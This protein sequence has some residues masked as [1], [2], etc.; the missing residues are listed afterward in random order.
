MDLNTYQEKA[1]ATDRVPSQIDT[2]DA[3]INLV[4]P[5][6]GLA[7]ETG[8]L[9]SEY[10][11]HLRDG[12]S[13]LL[14]K[15]R[16]SE[17]LG[18]L[19]WY[20]A[21]VAKKF[22]IKLSDIAEQNLRKVSG[23]W[24]PQDTGSV[25]FDSEYE[26]HERLPLSFEVE[27]SEVVID[28]RT[29]IQM[30][31]NGEK[32]GDDLTD[33]ADDPDGYRFHDVFHLA[34]VAVLGWSPVIRKLMKR[35]RKSVPKVDE[36]QDGGRAQ[37]LDEGVAALVF[38]YAKEHNW[39]EGVN[40]LDYKLLRTIKGITSLLEV[41]ERSVGEWQRAILIGF[42]VWRKVLQANGGRILVDQNT[43][44]LVFLGPANKPQ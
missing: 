34:Y 33:N 1:Q 39:L 2:S 15:E 29:M 20:I 35:K 8:E 42:E 6:L 12:N 43:R 21:N 3:G 17:E 41:R 18:D 44:N 25:S 16:V 27:L 14:F 4:V 37:V 5:L 40:D 23:R 31:I 11:K 36:V 32:I 24:G 22:D 9:L 13:H 10:K 26:E 28:D 30:R 7:G 19:L 38:D